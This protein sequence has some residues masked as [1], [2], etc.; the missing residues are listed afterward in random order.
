MIHTCYCRAAPYPHSVGTA[1][2][3]GSKRKS[4]LEP[5]CGECGCMRFSLEP[6]DEPD[7]GMCYVCNEC[8]STDIYEDAHCKDILA[9]PDR[10]DHDQ[11]GISL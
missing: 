5:R 2:C 8:E 9:V 4:F 7:T 10:R 1:G 6:C 11:D 3:Q